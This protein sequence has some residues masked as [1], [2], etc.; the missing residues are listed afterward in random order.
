[1]TRKLLIAAVGAILLTACD[2]KDPIYETDHPGKARVTLTAGWSG[3]DQ[4]ITKPAGYTAV[5]NGTAHTDIPATESHTFPDMAP[6]T[7]TAYLYNNADGIAISGTTATATYTATPPGWL[8]TGKLTETVEADKDYTFTVPMKQQV[9]ELTLVIEPT[10]GTADR[11][12]SISASLSGVAGM[13]DMDSDT[14]GSPSNA[15]L[16]FT[17]G[18]NGKWTATV[19][20][21]GVT[22]SEQKLTGTVAFEGGSPTDIMLDSDLSPSL[23]NFNRDKTTPLS[24]RGDMKETPTELGFV[25]SVTDWVR[26]DESVIAE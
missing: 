2:V 14:H 12:E 24:L 3:I 13:L 9:R 22:G 10:G 19:R 11:V 4:S 1:M 21:L 6:G 17:K 18:S 8:F 25:T 20:L 5:V 16:A 26:V 15:P 23:S 7:Y